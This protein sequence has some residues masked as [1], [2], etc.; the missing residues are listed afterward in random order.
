MKTTSDRMNAC[1]RP[2][3]RRIDSHEADNGSSGS[4]G[5]VASR[6][7]VSVTLAAALSVTS[8]ATTPPLEERTPTAVV[9]PLPMPV[10]ESG[11]FYRTVSTTDGEEHGWEVLE[12]ADDG[13]FVARDV[14]GCR[15]TSVADP[16]APGVA[17][18][19]CGG[20]RWG[21]GEATIASSS[22]GLWP[23]A[24]GNEAKWSARNVAK[25]GTRASSTRRCE[26]SGPFAVTVAVGDVD[27]LRVVCEDERARRTTYWTAEHGEVKK[28]V[29]VSGSLEYDRELVAIERR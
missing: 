26:V 29:V 23:L 4:I 10:R 21:T 1:A 28:T 24:P 16:F 6:V 25:D 17:W 5:R 27:A 14:D 22:G 3:D 12:V 7:T 11:T 15:W 8:C 9:P 20:G 13:T 19:G 18:S 2:I